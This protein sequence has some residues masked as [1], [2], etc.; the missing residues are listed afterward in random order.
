MVNGEWNLSPPKKTAAHPYIYFINETRKPTTGTWCPTLFYKW[1]GITYMPSHTDTAGHTK[2]I[3]Y[4]VTQTRLD[5]PRPLITLSHRHRWTYQDLWLPSHT[6]TAGHTKVID[7]PVTQTRLEIPRPLLTQ[8]HRHGWAYQGHWLPSH[9]DT[10]G[11]TKAFDYPVTQTRLDVPRPLITQSYRLDI[12]RP[13]IT[14]PHRHGWTYQG[15]WLPSHT[16]WTY[17]GLWLP[18]HTDTA[19]GFPPEKNLWG[20]HQ[21]AKGALW[22]GGLGPPPENFYFRTPGDAFSEHL[23]A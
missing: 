5:I 12:P 20:G 13:L 7:Y 23:R 1:H 22:A 21:R 6:D 16:G 11:H 17:Q 10:A 8:P 15:L 18:S 2:V 3:D 4:P 14:Q 19:A 9:T